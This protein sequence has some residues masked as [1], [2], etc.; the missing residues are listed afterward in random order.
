MKNKKWNKFEKLQ[1]KCYNN[2]IGAEEDATCWKQAF[3][4][5]MEIV[6]EERQ[7]NPNYASELEQLDDV[8]E[9][10]YDIMGWLEDC[11]DEIDMRK[12][13]QTL[14]TMC[15]TLLEEFGWPEYTGSDIKFRKSAVLKSLGREKE[16]VTFCE[17]W[18]AKEPENIVAAAAAVYAYIDV[19]NYE[20]AEQQV[21][22]FI[23]DKSRCVDENDI[24]FTA[25]SKLYQAMGRKKERTQVEKAMKAYE[26]EFEKQ[27]EL[28][29][30]ED[31]LDFLDD[32]EF[33]FLGNGG[34]LTDDDW[35]EDEFD[36]D[37]D[38]P[39]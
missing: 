26:K 10:G 32:D 28:D 39:F 25:A 36:E 27:M 30:L 5:M 16:A 24:M 13:Y 38:L 37:E 12:D 21:D 33:P 35:L 18:I 1:G 2:L 3:E 17:K 6:R 19:K 22:R 15:D 7:N 11:L 9:Y 4:L 29:L 31:A 23:P 20:K 8:T 34:F 14:L